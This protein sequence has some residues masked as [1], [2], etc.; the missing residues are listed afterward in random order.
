MVDST[1]ITQ[2]SVFVNHNMA[3]T[4]K[5]FFIEEYF[6]KNT[7]FK[8]LSD[9]FKESFIANVYENE[10]FL[11]LNSFKN[12]QPTNSSMN[13]WWIDSWFYTYNSL[14]LLTFVITIIFFNRFIF[15]KN[16]KRR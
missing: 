5:P 12:L 8:M 3:N 13:L 6:F 14:I 1:F 4:I 7:G 10:Y 16:C 9:S 15:T 2:N 11:F